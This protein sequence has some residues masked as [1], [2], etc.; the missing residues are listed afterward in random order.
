MIAGLDRER[1]FGIRQRW[2]LS[3]LFIAAASLGLLQAV[4]CIRSR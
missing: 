3:D 2:F 4:R 1:Y